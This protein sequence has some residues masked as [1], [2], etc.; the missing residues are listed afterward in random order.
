VRFFFDRRI[1]WHGPQR[2]MR[3]SPHRGSRMPPFFSNVVHPFVGALPGLS[4]SIRCS[5]VN[6]PLC[7]CWARSPYNRFDRFVPEMRLFSA[8]DINNPLTFRFLCHFPAKTLPLSVTPVF[9]SFSRPVRLVRYGSAPRRRRRPP[10][11][12]GSFIL[13]LFSFWEEYLKNLGSKERPFKT[14]LL[15]WEYRCFL[16]I[17]LCRRSE[18]LFFLFRS[19]HGRLFYSSASL[20]EGALFGRGMYFPS[21]VLF[22]YPPGAFSTSIFS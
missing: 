14:F 4:F 22:N 5:V 8:S 11:P 18:E 3:F 17:R 13:M 21:P 10:L 1:S 15:P 7:F 16:S 19:S 6:M 12:S 20:H 2:I 9:D